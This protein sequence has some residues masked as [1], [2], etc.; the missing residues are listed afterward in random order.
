MRIERWKSGTP[1]RIAGALC[2]FKF[3]VDYT[4]CHSLKLSK[5]ATVADATKMTGFS[6]QG[7]AAPTLTERLNRKDWT[8]HNRFFIQ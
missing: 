6:Q 8:T 5:W 4:D 1:R 2:R 7:D 3:A